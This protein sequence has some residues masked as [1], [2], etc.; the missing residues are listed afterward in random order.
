V[1]RGFLHEYFRR[2]GLRVSTWAERQL[3]RWPR[4]LVRWVLIG[5]GLLA[6]AWNGWA[7]ARALYKIFHH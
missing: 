4:G 1:K 5:L 2:M 3:T 6:A 7:L